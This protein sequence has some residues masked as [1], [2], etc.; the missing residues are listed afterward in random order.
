[1]ADR[2]PIDH[3]QPRARFRWSV[4]S[5]AWTIFVIL[6]V[7]VIAA[8][9]TRSILMDRYQAELAQVRAEI[10]A[11]GLPTTI[12]EIIP[13]PVPEAEDAAPLWYQVFGIMTAG[14][15]STAKRA[16][17]TTAKSIEAML[18]DSNEPAEKAN[19]RTRKD[20][21][22]PEDAAL[23]LARQDAVPELWSLAA[24]ASR[25][26]YCRFHR[27]WTT[28]AYV[29]MPETSQ[30]T[31][32]GKL[33][34]WRARCQFALNQDESAMQTLVILPGAARH[35]R[36]EPQ[37]ISSLIGRALDGRVRGELQRILEIRLVRI[38]NDIH[39]SVLSLA[40]DR[41]SRLLACDGERIILG[42][43]AFEQI[44]SDKVKLSGIVKMSDFLGGGSV[45]HWWNEAVWWVR[46]S[47]FG[48]P[49]IY[50]DHAAFLRLMMQYRKTIQESGSRSGENPGLQSGSTVSTSGPH[51]CCGNAVSP[52]CITPVTSTLSSGWISV[53][54][55]DQ[56]ETLLNTQCRFSLALAAV[57]HREGQ[58][59][60]DP[61]AIGIL[62]PPGLTYIRDGDRAI[63]GFD[64][65][66]AKQCNIP[67]MSLIPETDKSKESTRKRFL[68]YLAAPNQGKSSP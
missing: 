21:P 33:L 41:G 59:P 4:V 60:T 17:I 67:P 20:L 47:W 42:D 50:H 29:H 55:L 62:I 13:K 10:K 11:A 65:D 51:L 8:V 28:G 35:F 57:A 25:R 54:R 48:K 30:V 66:M 40:D 63:I 45:E 2:A 18:E 23:F 52:M 26:P 27:D 31:M 58:F 37:L 6:L 43:W 44:E 16:R 68:W 34:I 24:E 15:F 9:I 7:T 53:M 12:E 5:I 49:L 38:P 39:E 22:S 19:K 64:A 14:T 1:M 56:K 46:D 36:N 3:D 61:Q 32:L